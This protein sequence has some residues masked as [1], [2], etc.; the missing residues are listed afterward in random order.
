MGAH[1]RDSRSE[2]ICVNGH[3]NPDGNYF[4]GECGVLLEPGVVVCLA[5]HPNAHYQRFCGECGAPLAAPSD[6]EP[7]ASTARWSFD[8]TG[9]HQ[10]RYW[11]G[12]KWTDRIA[13]IGSLGTDPYSKG[14]GRL[15]E[16]WVGLAAGLVT[17][18]LLAGAGAD[19][20]VQLSRD[21]AKQTAT[22][23][24]SA[25]TTSTPSATDAAATSS[26][27]ESAL[28][29]SP[30]QPPQAVAGTTL[31]ATPCQ[32]GSGN[33][34][35]ADGSVTYCERLADTDRYLWSLNPGDI[36][37]PDVG[38]SGDPAVGVCMVQTG[39]TEAD[40]IQYLKPPSQAGN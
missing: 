21:A 27:V 8:P 30:S 25:T 38:Q 34:V 28:P 35:A 10:C 9:R 5:G 22:E 11:D 23:Q 29:A 33:G 37:A 4:C 40:C 20:W 2:V 31:I 32:P 1:A 24:I 17:V 18:A 6:V 13:D 39:R 7:M 19:I 14:A 3:E 15:A 26:S 12:I 36:P 16:T